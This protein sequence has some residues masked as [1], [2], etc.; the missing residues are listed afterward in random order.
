MQMRRFV[1]GHLMV[2]AEWLLD[3]EVVS[4]LVWSFEYSVHNMQ[5]SGTGKIATQRGEAERN[6]TAET[7][8]ANEEGPS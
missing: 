8:T 3:G 4:S 1:Q 2:A 7:L 6:G 5:K